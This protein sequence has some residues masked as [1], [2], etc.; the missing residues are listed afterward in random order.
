[1]ETHLFIIDIDLRSKVLSENGY[2]LA[3]IIKQKYPEINIIF[4]SGRL[5]YVWNSFQLKIFTLLIILFAFLIVIN[6]GIYLLFGKEI[7]QKYQSYTNKNY[8]E[9]IRTLNSNLKVFY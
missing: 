7:F 8:I 4:I 5:E 6:F 3:K 1:M 2:E 9:L